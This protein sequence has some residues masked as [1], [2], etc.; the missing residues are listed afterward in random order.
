MIDRAVVDQV[1]EAIDSF[2]E[3]WSSD[4]RFQIEALLKEYDLVEDPEALT[5]LIRIDIEFRYE[6]G[7]PCDISDYF[8]AFGKLRE[9][10]EAATQIAFEDYR[11]RSRNG[12]SLLSSRWEQVPGVESAAWFQELDASSRKTELRVPLEKRKFES[13]PAFETALKA[14]GFHI[15]HEIGQGAL[16]RVYLAT[17]QELADRYVVLKVVNLALSEPQSLAMLQHTN[18]VPIYSFHRIQSRSVICMPYAG[19]LTLEHFLRS[20]ATNQGRG[21]ESLI[22]T[23]QNRMR[24]TTVVGPNQEPGEQGPVGND[25]LSADETAVSGPLEKLR[26]LGCNELAIWI[27][28]R[29]ASALAHSHA[30]GVLHG[31]LKPANVLIRNDGEPALLDFNLAQSLDRPVPQLAGGT[32]PYIS[33]EVYRAL[34]GQEIRPECT[35][36]IYSL[37]V[38]LFEFVTGRLPYAVPNSMAPTDLEVA[39]ESRKQ[40]PDWRD[41]DD[42]SPGLQAI[43]NRCLAFAPNDRYESAEHLQQDLDCEHRDLSLMHASEPYVS[44]LKKWTHRHPRAVSGGSVGVL[45]FLLLI[46]II[47]TAAVSRNESNR[48]G[49]IAHYESFADQSKAALSTLMVDPR[50][51]EASSIAT[52]MQPLEDYGILDGSGL[53][54]FTAAGTSQQQHVLQRDTLLRHVVHIALAETASLRPALEQAPLTD[55]QLA[56]LDRLI[57]AA[58]EVRGDYDSRAVRFLH[59]KR[60]RLAGDDELATALLAQAQEMTPGSDSER[61]LEAVRMMAERKWTRALEMLTALADKNS[62]PSGLCWT[63]LG[64]SQFEAAKYEDAKLS[65]TQA[66]E[67]APRSSRLRYMRGLCYARLKIYSRAEADYT[68]ALDL[69]ENYLPALRNRGRCRRVLGNHDGA[70]KDFTAGLKIAPNEAEL[71]LARSSLYR[72]MGEP[73]LAERDMD[74]ALAAENLSVAS[75]DA[76]AGALMK[77]DPQRALEDMRRAR[78]LAPGEISL[79]TKTARIYYWADDVENAIDFLNRAVAIDPDYE[80]ALADRAII[81]AKQGQPALALAD[82]KKALDPPNFGRTHYQAAC[83]FASMPGQINRER[84]LTYLALSIRSGFEPRELFKDPDLEPLHDMKGFHSI[85]QTYRMGRRPGLARPQASTVDSP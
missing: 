79:Y 17:Q 65:I 62:I 57:A 43:I 8:D 47:W 13:D 9:N 35:S 40:G 70:I 61:Y 71:L 68:K 14:A 19:S 15:V 38:M 63:M 37:G 41:S 66:I 67:H 39:I 5:E 85:L 76:R 28:R 22:H 44:R 42:V 48:L 80:S 49:A 32:L 26:G 25:A 78:Q 73:E 33:P 83:A 12:L 18:I 2:E 52:A 58:E 11:G 31:D 24:R 69:E 59:A 77:D 16:S 51:H 64:R 34:M 82:L 72:E 75:L 6:R 27:F 30:R 45:L 56:P 4:S 20:E 7:L 84:A 50:R 21:G 23:V 55:D 54:R 36:D 3:N 10:P 46:P 29:L 53:S 74:A 1:E 60:A 81:Y